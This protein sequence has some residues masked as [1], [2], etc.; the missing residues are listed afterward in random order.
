MMGLDISFHGDDPAAAELDGQPLTNVPGF[1]N[2]VHVLGGVLTF[3]GES[4]PDDRIVFGCYEKC[5]A[6][7]DRHP[8]AEKRFGSYLSF[9]KNA[10]AMGAELAMP[11]DF[12]DYD[13]L[14]RRLAAA[15][16]RDEAICAT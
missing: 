9:L 16:L 6:Y 11:L 10:S 5:A 2:F 13:L 3:L 8:E 7:A 4:D 1:L 12:S 15:L 14:A